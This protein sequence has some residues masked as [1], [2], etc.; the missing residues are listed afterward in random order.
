MHTMRRWLVLGLSLAGMTGAPGSHPACRAADDA[1]ARARRFLAEHEARI[2]PLEIEVGKR[3]W[4]ANISGRDED[5]QAKQEIETR[6]DLALADRAKFAELKALHDQPPADPQLHR[7]IELLYRQYLPK[8]VDPQLLEQMLAKSN[9]IEKAFNT[10]RARVDEREL[11]DNAVRTVLKQSRDSGERRKVWEAS[12]RVGAAVEQELLALVGLRNQSAREAGFANYHV[13]QLYLAEQ[14]QPQILALFDELDQLTRE[15]FTRA[16]AEIDTALAAQSQVSISELRPWHYHDPFFQESPAVFGG[17]LDAVYAQ[18]DLV[19]LCRKFYAGIGL[20]I[21]DVLD[22]SDLFEKPGKSPHAFCIDIDRQGDVRV[23][24]NVVP[25]EQWMG[26][27][28]H[29]LGHAVYSSKNIPATLPYVLRSEAHILATEGVAMMLERFSKN[30]AWLQAMGVSVADPQAFDREGDRM[31]RNR[32]LIFSRWCQVMLRF[33]K[34]L[35]EDPTQDLNRLWWDLV[36]KF[37]QVRRPEDRAAPDYGSKIHIVSAPVYYH[38]YMLGELFACQVHATICREVLAG[39]DP[40]GAHYAGRKEVGDFMIRRV[41]APGRTLPWNE[42]TRH[43]T[44]A[45]LN[46]QAFAAEFRAE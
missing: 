41:F 8:Q 3:W 9:A 21:D 6:L 16:K 12:K 1:D 33:E 2:R 13:M 18:Q 29:E 36:E 24:C 39:A 32:L 34:A 19:A 42:L 5:F 23:L 27:L 43:A 44:G 7:Q 46:A 35:Y 30:A 11:T 38:N 40:R 37:Q 45:T 15:P 10:F 26:T 22:R 4:L 17:D 20:P 25:N 14:E 28:L 31:R